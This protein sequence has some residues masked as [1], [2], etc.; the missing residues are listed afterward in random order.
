MLLLQ[1]YDK[2]YKNQ[3]RLNSLQSTLI[4]EEYNYTQIQEKYNFIY[5]NDMYFYIITFYININ[6]QSWK[7]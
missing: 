5:I 2:L 1:L 6:Q 4:Q 3:R 7:K